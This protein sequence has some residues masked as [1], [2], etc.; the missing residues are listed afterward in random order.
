MHPYLMEQ[1]AVARQRELRAGAAAPP[2]PPLPRRAWHHPG[3]RPVRQRA[4][5][6]LIEIGLRLARGADSA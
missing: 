1:L 3:R 5:W 6:M 2:G 4:G